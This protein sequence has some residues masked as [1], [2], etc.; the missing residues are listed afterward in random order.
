[1]SVRAVGVVV[2]QALASHLTR[3]GARPDDE[4]RRAAPASPVS[5]RGLDVSGAHEIRGANDDRLQA[6]PS[7]L[8]T[9]PANVTSCW[10][11]C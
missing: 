5:N 4:H 9:T 1:M 11:S 6:A 7:T 8:R 10:C 3:I 2:V